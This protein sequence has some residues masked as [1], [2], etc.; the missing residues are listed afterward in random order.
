MVFIFLG[1]AP[2]HAQQ[3]LHAS[4]DSESGDAREFTCPL[5]T[6]ASLQ[7]YRFKANF[8]GSHDDTTMSMAATLNG[9]PLTCEAGSTT[10][11]RFEDGDVSLDCRFSVEGSAGAQNVLGVNLVWSHAQ[12]TDFE[13]ISD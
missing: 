6:P 12:Y 13:L 1:R 2:A 9:A 5:E 7:R 8:S 11:R 3:K 4:R 10:S